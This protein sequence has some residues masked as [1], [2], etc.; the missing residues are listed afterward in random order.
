MTCPTLCDE[1]SESYL[2]MMEQLER[3][4]YRLMNS[5]MNPELWTFQDVKAI[6]N[7][8]LSLHESLRG[9]VD[10]PMFAWSSVDDYLLFSRR[11]L[12]VLR[13]EYGVEWAPFLGL[14]DSALKFLGSVDEAELPKT[15]VH[16]DF[17]PRNIAISH[18]GDAVVYDFE[19]ARVDV[20]HRDLVE[21]LS[22]VYSGADE[23]LNLAELMTLFGDAMGE[24]LAQTT[25][26]MK[27]ALAKYVATRMSLYLLGH[28]ITQY[29]FLRQVSD[30]CVR[31]GRELGLL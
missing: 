4:D 14:Y 1:P 5:E 16:N 24:E 26:H 9:F 22:F 17:N 25:H 18:R 28:R 13:D 30:N 10:D 8:A 20:P 7:V 19:L 15:V 2:I 21:F 11:A 6:I 3:S 29:P 23:R 12:S 27:F 31:L